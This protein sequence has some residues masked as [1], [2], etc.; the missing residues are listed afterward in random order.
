MQIFCL[1]LLYMCLAMFC[2]IE[3]KLKQTIQLYMMLAL[4]I[5][6]SALQYQS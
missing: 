3:I 4:S 1:C 6:F 5:F 2:E